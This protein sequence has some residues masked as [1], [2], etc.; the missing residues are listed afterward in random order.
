MMLVFTLVFS[1][2]AHVPTDGIPYA[3]FCLFGTVVVEL[4]FHEPELDEPL[5][6]Q[7]QLIT[8]VCFRRDIPSSRRAPC[9]GLRI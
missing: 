9:D 2:I 3:L 4:Y 6:G 8:K 1:R 5:V 7:A